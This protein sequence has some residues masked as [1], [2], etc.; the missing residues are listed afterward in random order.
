MT[1][2]SGLADSSPGVGHPLTKGVWA[3]PLDAGGVVAVV[4]AAVAAETDDTVV[5]VAAAVV[6]YDGVADAEDGTGCGGDGHTNPLALLSLAIPEDG[7]CC[8]CWHEASSSSLSISTTALNLKA[9]AT[10]ATASSLS[11]MTRLPS[12]TRPRRS[13]R[14]RIQPHPCREPKIK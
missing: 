5:V 10:P 1:G 11:T 9:S 14:C 12:L 2:G 13:R 6:D 4:A 7:C 3:R 8:C